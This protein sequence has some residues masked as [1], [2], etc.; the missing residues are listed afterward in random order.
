MQKENIIK[1][2]TGATRYEI[3]LLI[4]IVITLVTVIIIWIWFGY[5][6]HELEREIYMIK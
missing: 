2:F 1:Q 3:L 5:K 6:N 4:C